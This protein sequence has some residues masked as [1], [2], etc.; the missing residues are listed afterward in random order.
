MGWN[1]VGLYD[2]I[3]LQYKTSQTELER[4]EKR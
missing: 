1:M 2:T 3:D 4:R